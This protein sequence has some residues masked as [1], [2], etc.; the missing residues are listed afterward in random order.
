MFRAH[1]KLVAAFLVLGIVAA[2]VVGMVYAWRN[3]LEPSFQARQ[4]I[5]DLE[6]QAP[7]RID[8]GNRVFLEA[9]EHMNAGDVVAA[10]KKL[11]QLVTTYDDSESYADSRR[12]LGEINMDQLLSDVRTA[13]KIDYEVV[14]GDSLNRIA[15]R[16][17]TTVDYIML[18]N[19]LSGLTLQRGDRLLVSELDFKVTVNLG[20]KTLRLEK[21]DKAFK[22]YPIQLARGVRPTDRKLESRSAFHDG[23]AVSVGRDGY[24]GSEKWLSCGIGVIIGPYTSE[25]R[26]DE[27]LRGIFLDG[28]DMEELYTLLRVGTPVRIRK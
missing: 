28:A 24:I 9:M 2:S 21:D 22:D 25:T 16:Q 18:V 7:K 8:V 1:L 10:H 12:I 20:D 4:E 6:K 27:D 19:G 5:L 15:S 26:D 14:S 17:K 11:S 13:G 23:R 3:Y